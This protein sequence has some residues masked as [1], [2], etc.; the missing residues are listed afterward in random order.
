MEFAQI[1][2]G[3]VEEN[4]FGAGARA[5]TV[6]QSVKVLHAPHG[7]HIHAQSVAVVDGEH[8]A[9]KDDIQAHNANAVAV[10]QECGTGDA[11]EVDIGAV[12][13]TVAQFPF[14]VPN[15]N[16]TVVAGYV[17]LPGRLVLIVNDVFGVPTDGDF[18]FP[19]KGIF[20]VSREGVFLLGDNDRDGFPSPQFDFHLHTAGDCGALV[21]AAVHA[22]FPALRLE[23]PDVAGLILFLHLLQ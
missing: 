5:R 21:G 20:T 14:A 15:H 23:F 1:A 10:M 22:Q 18:L 8:I 13:G 17:V 12:T 2:G 4:L 6:C 9:Q 11:P 19:G 3:T 7:R 16:G